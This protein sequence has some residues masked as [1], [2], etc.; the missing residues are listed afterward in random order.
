[1][2]A[3]AGGDRWDRRFAG[4]SRQ[5][6]MASPSERLRSCLRG[7]EG[8]TPRGREEEEK[9]IRHVLLQPKSAAAFV[10]GPPGSGKTHTVRCVVAQSMDG[11]GTEEVVDA[12]E[13]REEINTLCW[14]NCMSLTQPGDLYRNLLGAME[15]TAAAKGKQDAKEAWRGALKAI[16]SR[17]G[18]GKRRCSIVLVLDECD[19]FMA[20]RVDW[21]AAVQELCTLVAARCTLKL[22]CVS[23]SPELAGRLMPPLQKTMSQTDVVIFEAYKTEEIKHVLMDLLQEG[24]ILH[25]FSPPAL[26]FCAK[27][28]GSQSGDMRYAFCI[29]MRALEGALGD[30]AGDGGPGRETAAVE[31]KRKPVEMEHIHAA[32]QSNGHGGM[33]KPSN[34][35]TALPLHQR[36]VLFTLSEGVLA[37]KDKDATMTLLTTLHQHYERNCRKRL[38]KP[39]S[40]QQVAAACK[41]LSDAGL[42]QV[43]KP[44]NKKVGDTAYKLCRVVDVRAA[45]ERS[46]LT[47]Q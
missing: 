45:L 43:H 16:K 4:V 5:M 21:L 37:S 22:I 32:F 24:G 31:E 35:I 28:I 15:P 30:A 19:A 1:M 41:D 3:V 23:N 26:Q 27:K 47:M 39:L 2:G 44:R 13:E 18:P 46:R 42:V 25:W 10:A 7:K 40:F 9:R 8:C 34:T 17:N 6:A 14:I 20:A 36:L 29:C 11:A 33:A 38:V 12:S